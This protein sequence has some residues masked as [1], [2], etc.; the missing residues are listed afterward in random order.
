M[1]H[2]NQLCMNHSPAFL[3]LVNRL[4]KS[5]EESDIKGLIA[6]MNNPEPYVLIDVREETEYRAGNIP[7][8][9]WIGKGI[10]E[11]D[12]ESR[13]PD[14][15]TELWLYCGGG[16]RSV[17]AADNLQKM[18]Y[19]HVVSVDGGFRAWLDTGN[20]IVTPEPER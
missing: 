10:L 5:V 4:R 2:P 8:S 14:K 17:L 9:L 6:R 12:I 15:D 11:R 16:Y 1:S 19:T 7:G 18:G 20:P 13:V 3:S